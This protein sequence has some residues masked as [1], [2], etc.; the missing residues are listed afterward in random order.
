M[1]AV[2]RDQSNDLIARFSCNTNWGALDGDKLQKEVNQMPPEELG[3]RFTAFLRDGAR[4]II[5]P[6]KTLQCAKVPHL[7]DIMG[8]GGW[9]YI[10]SERDLRAHA[11]TEINWAKLDFTTCLKEGEHRITGGE[12]LKRLKS[13][14]AIRLGS[15]AFNSLWLDYEERGAQS[16]L[17]Q[18]Y[19]E[20]NITS[21][22]FFG[23]VILSPQGR[24][25]ILCLYHVNDGRWCWR[26]DWLGNYRDFRKYIIWR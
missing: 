10:A 9:E 4:L 20:Q 17:E 24:R 12:K 11:L 13:S 6:D 5:N 15:R 7:S 8:V 26:H 23:D 1:K 14:G 25:Y 22:D 2:T 3:R 18:L 19:W 21:I 16:V